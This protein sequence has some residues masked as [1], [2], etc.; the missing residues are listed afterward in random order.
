VVIEIRVKYPGGPTLKKGTDIYIFWVVGFLAVGFYLGGG[1]ETTASRFR[2][3]LP[4]AMAA[5]LPPRPNG[6][7]V[8]VSVENGRCAS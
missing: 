8:S 6:E 7:Q 5:A 4:A 3:F 1:H 2:R